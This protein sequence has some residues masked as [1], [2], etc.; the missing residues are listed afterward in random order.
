MNN[1]YAVPPVT[2]TGIP[3]DAD[4]I[5]YATAPFTPSTVHVTDSGLARFF[6]RYLLQRAISVFD[7]D[8]PNDWDKNYFL[9]VLYCWGF[10][11]IVKT[12]KFGVIAQ[13]CG[14]KGYNIYYQPTHAV[15]TNPLLSG[16]LEPRIGVE[17]ELIR[18]QPDYGGIMDLVTYYSDMLALESQ[19]L[20][21]N[22]LN[23]KLS[24]GFF[25]EDKQTAETIKKFYDSFAS[26]EPLTITGK[27]LF[28][29]DGRKRYEF[30]NQDV[31]NQYIADRILSDMRKI[32]E[33][34]D[35]EIGIPN[36]NTDKKERLI[37]DEI[38]AN[39]ME[40]ISRCGLW[41]EELK[42]SCEKVNNMFGLDLSVNW[43][44]DLLPETSLE[45]RGDENEN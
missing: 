7:W 29:A 25:A 27:N 24:Y 13:G 32:T 30:F 4:Y 38:N 5:N 2:G 20:A 37:T 16:I 3:F 34:F 15:I 36:A 31:K 33:M 43:R 21:V 10:L 9:Y 18:L 12:D 17:C 19:S 45:M 39:N 8:I 41:L 40:T 44:R 23:S 22:I 35:T 1:N 14:L 26:G 28:D 11:A 6:R 42:K